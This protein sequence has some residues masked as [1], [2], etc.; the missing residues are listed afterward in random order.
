LNGILA[1]ALWGTPDGPNP[2]GLAS[3][4]VAEAIRALIVAFGIL[5]P[6]GTL[7]AVQGVLLGE[8]LDGTLAWLLSMPIGR[9]AV[10][11]AKAAA[12]ASGLLVTMLVVPWGMT[13]VLVQGRVGPAIR[14]DSLALA[15][16]LFGLHILFYV[17]LGLLLGSLVPARGWVVAIGALVL[18][19]QEAGLDALGPVGA[20]LPA[21]LAKQ[22][23]QP[24]LLGQDMGSFVP[25]DATIAWISVCLI[26]AAWRLPRQD[27]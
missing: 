22:L 20:Y 3:D 15:F 8:Q 6:L 18:V 11:L 16:G 17:S 21:A 13:L 27:L 25:I 9:P 4:R 23:V 24:L 2:A 12:R 1:A 10:L 7:V 14:P 5:A 26:V 19:A